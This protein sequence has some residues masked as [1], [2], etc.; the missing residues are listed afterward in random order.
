VRT[1]RALLADPEVRDELAS[2]GF[3]LASTSHA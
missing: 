2:L 1:F 3:R